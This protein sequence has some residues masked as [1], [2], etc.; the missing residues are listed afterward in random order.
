MKAMFLLAAIFGASKYTLVEQA[1]PSKNR[2]LIKIMVVFPDGIWACDKLPKGVDITEL[3]QESKKIRST[4]LDSGLS[5]SWDSF[6]V[7]Y[8]RV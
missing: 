8:F 5:S 2:S 1:N 6:D 4:I 7:K 3:M